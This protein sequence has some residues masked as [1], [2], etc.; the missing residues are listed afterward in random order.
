MPFFQ[1]NPRRSP[2][3]ERNR[4]G[5]GPPNQGRREQP[6]F[7]QYQGR[8]E[9][10]FFNQ[11]RGRQ[12]QP[13]FNQY[14]GRQEQPFYYQNQGFQEQPYYYPD[15]QYPAPGLG[16]GGLT[17]NLNTLMGHAGTITNGVNMFRQLGS[18]M[19]LFR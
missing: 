8:R 2:F 10:S 12:E 4:Q 13:F 17:N 15:Q 9:Q 7:N 11:N 16:G 14:Q 3:P 6:F 18:I 5:Y 19:S 1:P